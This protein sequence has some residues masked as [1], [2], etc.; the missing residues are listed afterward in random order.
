MVSPVS[1]AKS[2]M[3]YSPGVGDGQ[4]CPPGLVSEALP[5]A[6]AIDDVFFRNTTTHWIFKWCLLSKSG[7]QEIYS[8]IRQR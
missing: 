4:V 2:E 3:V 7:M 5:R 1:K 8:V 6:S